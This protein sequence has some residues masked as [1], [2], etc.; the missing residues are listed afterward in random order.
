M[1]RILGNH[2]IRRLFYILFILLLAVLIVAKFF[3]NGK[4]YIDSILNDLIASIVTTVLIGSFAFY[5][6]PKAEDL[7]FEVIEPT[8]IQ[9]ELAKGRIGT[10]HWYFTG[11]TGIFTRAVTLPE[12]AKQARIANKPIELKLQLIDPLNNDICQKYAEYRR[13]LNTASGNRKLWTATFVRNHSFATIIKAILI[14]SQE[15]LL[16]ISI[17]LKN[18]FSLFRLDLS[19]TNVVVTKEDP[20]EVAFVFHKN[21]TSFNSYIHEFRETF[22]QTRL[23]KEYTTGISL[24]ELDKEKL[25]KLL[26]DLELYSDVTNDDLEF[27]LDLVTNSKNPYA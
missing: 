17:G 18:N 6:F 25:T 10:D 19:S 12:L 21:S 23:V 27:I 7:D 5:V 4:P 14:S 3:L 26:R 9:Q 22:K 15:P 13:G 8:R 24:E 2:K 11:G 16:D 1:E 20:R